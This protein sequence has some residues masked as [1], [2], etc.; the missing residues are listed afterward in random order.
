MADSAAFDVLKLVT[1]LD[2]FSI[3]RGAT[4]SVYVFSNS[5]TRLVLGCFALTEDSRG[6]SFCDLFDDSLWFRVGG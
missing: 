2:L 1:E 6:F 4:M 5:D 3:G